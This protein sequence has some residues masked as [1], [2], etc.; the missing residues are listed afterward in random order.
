MEEVSKVKGVI[1]F[2]LNYEVKASRDFSENLND[3]FNNEV[4]QETL[5]QYITEI[6]GVSE[7]FG[8]NQPL[9]SAKMEDD[10][11]V[12]TDFNSE[13][14]QVSIYLFWHSEK[15]IPDLIVACI[16][17]FNK[18]IKE[19][20]DRSLRKKGGLKDYIARENIELRVFQ[21]FENGKAIDTETSN[22]ID[23]L[24]IQRIEKHGVSEI[25]YNI[26]AIVV[27]FG[28]VFFISDIETAIITI[29]PFCTVLAKIF[30]DNCK[31]MNYILTVKNFNS[32]SAT[33]DLVSD[34]T[35][36]NEL[37]DVTTPIVNV[38][39]EEND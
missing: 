17:E 36:G 23:N 35:S 8:V 15:P 13:D 16:L 31:N 38:L 20:W 12:V 28:I 21:A 32:L 6:Q 5:S 4:K 33:T 3:I 18:I 19:K 14:R 37:L 24:L 30:W 34:S 26:L 1:H 29:L 9:Y 11:F 22:R 2:K 39:G 25:I 27:S 7:L 10:F